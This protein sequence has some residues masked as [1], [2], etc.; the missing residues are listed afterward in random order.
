MERA[1]EGRQLEEIAEKWRLLKGRVKKQ[2]QLE[3]IATERSQIRFMKM[4]AMSRE[5]VVELK[6]ITR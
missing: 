2:R 4:G 1:E 3:E 5:T 6:V